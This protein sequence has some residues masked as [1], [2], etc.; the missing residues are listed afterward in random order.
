MIQKQ[1]RKVSVLFQDYNT[2]FTK[3][4]FEHIGNYIRLEPVCNYLGSC[5]L[6]LRTT[7]YNPRLSIITYNSGLNRNYVQLRYIL[8]IYS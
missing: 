3:Y 1:L 5:T 7:P 6:S 4:P 2:S 8:R